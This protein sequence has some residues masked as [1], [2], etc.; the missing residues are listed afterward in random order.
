MTGEGVV[1]HRAKAKAPAWLQ[2]TLLLP[3]VG[4]IPAALASSGWLVAAIVL[5]VSFLLWVLFS[6]LRVTVS[7]TDVNIQYGLFGPKIPIAAI[8]SAEATTYD[9]KKFGGWGIK[10]SLDG[11]WI[12]N[13]PGDQGHA[14]RIVWRTAKGHRRVT[15]V[16]S[17][18]HHAMARAIDEARTRKG[19]ASL[20]ETPSPP[21]LPPHGDD[22]NT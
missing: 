13:M 14:V 19:T 18:E 16:G 15:L 17:R 11:E 3:A 22:S 1:L 6:V 7:D 20:S 12:Y 10:R 4:V 9:W 21:A 2:A 5:P 8:E